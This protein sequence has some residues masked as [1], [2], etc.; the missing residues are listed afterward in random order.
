MDG[1]APQ[2]EE[3]QED[4]VILYHTLARDGAL[5]PGYKREFAT[6]AKAI[7]LAAARAQRRTAKHDREKGKHEEEKV[8]QQ[9][10]AQFQW[11]AGERPRRYRTGRGCSTTDPLPG[12]TQWKGSIASSFIGSKDVGEEDENGASLREFAEVWAST[13]KIPTTPPGGRG[14]TP[15]DL[16]HVLITLV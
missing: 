10:A 8:E 4:V 16:S 13:W 3:P 7:A 12:E 11:T 15:R 6:L 1:S 9:T 2:T 14:C 5:P